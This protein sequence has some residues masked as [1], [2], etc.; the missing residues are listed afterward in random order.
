[1]RAAR[2]TLA[3]MVIVV[4]CAWAAWS[5]WPSGTA[6]GE[7]VG[8][9]AG[10]SLVCALLAAMFAT[11]AATLAVMR[12]VQC[13]TFQGY[14]VAGASVAATYGLARGMFAVCW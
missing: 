14:F 4:A 6:G 9:A 2:A 1:M 5:W 12:D 8:I 10:W 7:L 13:R 3:A 11:T